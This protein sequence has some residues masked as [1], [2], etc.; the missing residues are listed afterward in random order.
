MKT[1]R[2]RGAGLRYNG[3][4]YPEGAEGVRIA[5]DDAKP[6][7]A[8]GRLEQ[9]VQGVSEA[10][11]DRDETSALPGSIAAAE[12]LVHAQVSSSPT[13]TPEP[14]PDPEPMPEPSPEP[15]PEP[16][17]ARKRK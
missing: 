1:Y 13:P 15:E 11:L 17:P 9:M 2:V 5:D 4:R 12:A 3:T 10:E 7:L 6:L 14:A 16:E 8:V